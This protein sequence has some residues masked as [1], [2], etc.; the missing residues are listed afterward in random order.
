MSCYTLDSKSGEMTNLDSI[1]EKI[2]GFP[3]NFLLLVISFFD[4]KS[5]EMT[6]LDSIVEEPTYGTCAALF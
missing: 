4:T 1:V 3:V 2:Q 6:N 5:V